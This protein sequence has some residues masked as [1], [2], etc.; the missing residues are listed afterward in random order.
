[1]PDPARV[2]ELHNE[3]LEA[4]NHQIAAVQGDMDDMQVRADLEKEAP[5]N[6]DADVSSYEV[7]LQQHKDRME[8]LKKSKAVVEKKIAGLSNPK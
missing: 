8:Q 7:V 5:L 1:M 6:P 4:I 3:H 2:L